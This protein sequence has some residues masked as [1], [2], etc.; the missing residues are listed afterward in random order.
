MTNYTS[1]QN[2]VITGAS[3]LKPGSA[4][5][6][7][8]FAGA[9]K[10]TTLKGVASTLKGTT[11][12]LA[13]NREIAN[14]AQN[15]FRD[16]NT[17]ASTMHSLAIKAVR[18][19][20]TEPPISSI[21][22]KDVLE[23]RAFKRA[24]LPRVRKWHDF[25]IALAVIRTMTQ[26]A[27]SDDKEFK[28][29]HAR[30]AI[31][32]SLGDPDLMLE[33]IKRRQIED[34][35][36]KFEN[37]LYKI[38]RDVWVTMEKA[39]RYTHD[40]Y[41]KRLDWSDKSRE[42]AFSDLDAL[43]ID[44]A[45]DIN[46]VQISILK[47]TGLPLI[48]VGDP[49]QQIYSW[50]GAENALEKLPGDS[51]YLTQSFRFSE[52]IARPAR[53]ILSSRPDGGPSNKLIGAGTGNGGGHTGIPWA[54]IC[55]TNMGV[56]DAA[57]DFLDEGYPM[58]I[59]NID[60]LLKDLR[61][62]ESLFNDEL[63]KVDTPELKPYNSWQELKDEAEEGNQTLKKIVSLVERKRVGAVTALSMAGK[64]KGG[65][66]PCVFLCTAHRS[67]GLEFP[68]IS[69]GGD[70]KPMSQMKKR[71]ESSK[72]GT[73]RIM[74]MEEWNTLYVASTRAMVSLDGLD[75]LLET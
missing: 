3:L 75:K 64:K 34:S 37:H 63:D 19:R 24:N 15:K 7:F 11:G 49:Y 17:R 29:I 43:M 35:I 71:Y 38:A 18:H 39:G 60:A 57:L 9:G 30:R 45:Q 27:Q 33:G 52:N 21:P 6:V 73:Q 25:R 32:E 2:A 72:P 13:F 16:T 47:Q 54:K 74:A 51:F 62:A 4:Q 53:R 26:F 20:M 67:K 14:E 59:D 48:A 58:K 5:K 70:W 12:Y 28:P 69:L 68:R 23:S 40:M 56:I 42:M 66:E 50:R 1:E 8:A 10:T 65:E 31:I 44:E 22:A 55:R 41:L 61:S 46:A 36:L